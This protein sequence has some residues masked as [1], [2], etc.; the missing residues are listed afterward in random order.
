MIGAAAGAV[1]T[2]VMDQFW[3]V[4]GTLEEDGGN[5]GEDEEASFEE[6]HHELDDN[7]G[8]GHRVARG[9]VGALHTRTCRR[10]SPRLCAG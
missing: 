4:I 6:E 9:R 5:G 7:R 2:L 3:K 8:H 10:R 1:G